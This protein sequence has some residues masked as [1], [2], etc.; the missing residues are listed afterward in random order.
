MRVLKGRAG[1]RDSGACRAWERGGQE[2][3][4]RG[5]GFQGPVQEPDRGQFFWS[6]SRQPLISRRL[7]ALPRGKERPAWARQVRGLALCQ[8]CTCLGPPGPTVL[9]RGLPWPQEAARANPR[10]PDGET[11]TEAGKDLNPGFNTEQNSMSCSFSP[12]ADQHSNQGFL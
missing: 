12:E 9:C 2:D 5:S 10:S 4:E 11:E 6:L 7:L 3:K 1:T 8:C